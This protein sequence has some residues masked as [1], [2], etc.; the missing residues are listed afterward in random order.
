MDANQQNSGSHMVI[1][2]ARWLDP[3]GRWHQGWIEVQGGRIAAV[4][5]GQPN[6]RLAGAWRL[7]AEGRRVA[8]G[9]IDIHI[10]GS[11]GFD[12]TGDLEQQM[13]MAGVMPRHGVTSY[14]AAV[15][16][17]S[18]EDMERAVR[19]VAEAIKV[20]ATGDLG[21]KVPWQAEILGSHL[22]GP[23]ISMEYKGAHDPL[24]VRDPS[25]VELSLWQEASSRTIRMVTLAPELPG[26][27]EAIRW[28]KEHGIVA[29]VGHTA[30]TYGQVQEAIEAGATHSV[31]CFNAMRPLHHRE[32]GA[33]G[34][35]LSDRR[36]TA[37]L[38]A[39]FVHV[40]PAACHV[41]LSS[42]GHDGLALVTDAI[43]AAGMAP[44]HYHLGTLEV[45]VSEDAARLHD[46]TLAGSVLT[47]DKAVRNVV[48]QG[49]LTAEEALH[50]ASAVP[51]RV[52]GVQ[53][54]KGSIEAGKDADLICLDDDLQVRWTMT[55]GTLAYER[56]A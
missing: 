4:G 19:H 34:A 39:D 28:L 3:D 26:G 9:L 16:S 18:V 10:H 43:A 44:G 52:V 14:V 46:G 29:N 50:R 56:K 45:V 21:R 20:Q 41:A 49:L 24:V 55:R 15:V 32:P 7:S 48:R 12:C 5:E 53:D 2:D 8:P 23:F 36:I 1:T 31:H 40:H 30:A 47:L 17:G 6:D 37:E 22:E 42:K 54:R 25:I 11:D 35:I 13:G 27:L 51:A 38:I 33:T